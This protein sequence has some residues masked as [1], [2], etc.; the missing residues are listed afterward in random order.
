M[1]A[2]TGAKYVEGSGDTRWQLTSVS[3]L[4][5]CCWAPYGGLLAFRPGVETP[6]ISFGITYIYIFF[7]D[8]FEVGY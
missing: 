2:E 1:R 7:C 4:V 3:W 6:P 5:A 8:N